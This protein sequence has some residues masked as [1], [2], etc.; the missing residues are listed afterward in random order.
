MINYQCKNISDRPDYLLC[1]INPLN[2]NCF[3]CNEYDIEEYT[4][5]IKQDIEFICN[6]FSLIQ[7]CQS[8]LGR[9]G[10]L[11]LFSSFLLSSIEESIFHDELIP[12]FK[13]SYVYYYN[14]TKDNDYLKI[15][16]TYSNKSI[17]IPSDIFKSDVLLNI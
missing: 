4:P 6:M 3:N 16:F 8:Y 14:N 2:K 1:S 13:Y 17:V 7:E 12:F 15:V 10:L 5:E 11:G 9:R